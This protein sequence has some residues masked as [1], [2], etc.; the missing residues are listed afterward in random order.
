M[1]TKV[2]ENGAAVN[3]QKPAAKDA[4][5]INNNPVNKEA[6]KPEEAKAGETQK[7]GTHEQTQQPL[8]QKAESEQP[9]VE[10]P[11]PEIKPAKPALNLESTL[12]LVEELHRRK[13]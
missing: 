5:F 8:L 9:K 4:A 7:E 2:K 12:K 1:E 6:V 13:I 10:Q 3:G 11:K